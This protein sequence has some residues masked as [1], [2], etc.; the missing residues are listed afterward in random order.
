MILKVLDKPPKNAKALIDKTI[1]LSDV[2]Y[3]G[4]VKKLTVTLHLDHNDLNQIVALRW[5]INGK[6]GK[7][8][9]GDGITLDAWHTFEDA[10]RKEIYGNASGAPSGD[11]MRLREAIKKKEDALQR[12]PKKPGKDSKSRKGSIPKPKDKRKAKR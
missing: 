2:E 9:C 6:A 5:V 7:K 8:I 4:K 3:K 11:L 1:D 10:V 12:V